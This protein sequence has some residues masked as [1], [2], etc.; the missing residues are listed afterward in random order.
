MKS[1]QM[2]QI[3]KTKQFL[4]GRELKHPAKREK[5]ARVVDYGA[6]F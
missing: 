3:K 6:D 1:L 5:T 2:R 4:N